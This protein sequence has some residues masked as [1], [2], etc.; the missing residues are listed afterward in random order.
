MFSSVFS[1]SICD[2]FFSKFFF[3]MGQNCHKREIVKPHH[4]NIELGSHFPVFLVTF[5]KGLGNLD[6]QN[7]VFSASSHSS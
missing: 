4:L 1:S 6:Y 3:C 7:S 5:P 2:S